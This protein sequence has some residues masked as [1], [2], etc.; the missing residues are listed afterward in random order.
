MS[1][2]ICLKLRVFLIIYAF[3]YREMGEVTDRGMYSPAV[4]DC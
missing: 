4:N 1:I 3:M 2:A